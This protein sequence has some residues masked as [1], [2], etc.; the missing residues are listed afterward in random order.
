MFALKALPIALSPINAAFYAVNNSLFTSC[1]VFRFVSVDEL[2]GP[3]VSTL[4]KCG[5]YSITCYGFIFCKCIDGF[6]IMYK[7]CLCK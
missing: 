2:Y 3:I 6:I 7:K 4:F 5:L 1:A